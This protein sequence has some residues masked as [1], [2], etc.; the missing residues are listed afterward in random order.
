MPAAAGD[1][2][3][4]PKPSLYPEDSRLE[5]DLIE[6]MLA[7]LKVWRPDLKYPES[8]SDMQALARAALSVFKIERRPLPAPLRLRC[9]SCEGLGK[10]I[11]RM[12]S[13]A[14]HEERCP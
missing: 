4:M 5:H 3:V 12:L 11:T 1:G 9:D 6:T 14:H 13:G 10:F 7:G 2:R 8:H